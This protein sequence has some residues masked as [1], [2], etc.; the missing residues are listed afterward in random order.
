ML[1]ALQITYASTTTIEYKYDNKLYQQTEKINNSIYDTNIIQQEP[2]QVKVD[3]SYV[4]M[5]NKSSYIE[6]KTSDRL[7]TDTST[8]TIKAK[9]SCGCRYKYCWYTSTF[10]NKCPHCGKKLL[11]NPKGV[12]EKELTCSKCS[13]DY[14]GVCGKEKY[15]WSKYYLTKA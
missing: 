4:N 10:I 1:C 8:I 3:P 7:Y 14:C 12:Y 5:N 9:P 2:K 6:I 11:I 13:A 15:S